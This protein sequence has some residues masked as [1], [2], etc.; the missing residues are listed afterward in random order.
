MALGRAQ[1]LPRVGEHPTA[2]EE[3][4]M[5]PPRRFLFILGEFKWSTRQLCPSARPGMPGSRRPRRSLRTEVRAAAHLRKLVG[6]EPMTQAFRERT[7]CGRINMASTVRGAPGRGT[8]PPCFSEGR[9]PASSGLARLKGRWPHPTCA[10]NAKAVATCVSPELTHRHV[11]QR[12]VRCVYNQGHAAF[13][14][15][16]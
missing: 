8:E 9:S 13:F 7:G 2:Q 12:A 16:V 3:S 1:V 6:N 5:S 15:A 10:F 14:C 11:S 4:W